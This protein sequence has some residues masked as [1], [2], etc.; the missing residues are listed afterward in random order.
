VPATLQEGFDDEPATDPDGN[1]PLFGTAPRTSIYNRLRPNAVDSLGSLAYRSNYGFTNTTDNDTASRAFPQGHGD[2]YG[3]YLK[4]TKV[5]LEAFGAGVVDS[6]DDNFALNLIQ[7]QALP[8]DSIECA[9][10]DCTEIVDD[11]GVVHQVG[12]HG[13]RSMATAMAARSRTAIRVVDLTFRRDYREHGRTVLV[14][15][16]TQRSWGVADWGHRGG[17]GAYLDWAVLNQLLVVPSDGGPA[18]IEAVDRT[19]VEQVGTLAVAVDEIQERVDAAGAGLDPLGLMPNVVPFR[20]IQPGQLLNFLEG[21]ASAGKSHYGIVRDAA[22]EAIRNARGIL[23]RANAAGNRLR[24]NEEVLS[25]FENQVVDADTA[26]TSR[27]IEIFGLPSPSDTSDNDGE[28]NNGD[29]VQEV[30]GVNDPNDDFRESGCG[31][32]CL[33]TPDLR[34]FLLDDEALETELGWENRLATG[35]IQ[36]TMASL[37]AASIKVNIAEL[38]LAQLESLIIDKAKSLALTRGEAVETIEI[39]AEACDDQLTVIGRM[40]K[41]AADRRLREQGGGFL[42]LFVG[43]VAC[44]GGGAGCGELVNG[45]ASAALD[46]VTDAF[47]GISEESLSDE[48]FDIQREELRINCWQTAQLTRISN[49]QQVRALEIEL[50]NLMRSTPQAILNLVLARN[51]ARQ[52]LGVLNK[53]VQAGKRL[54]ADRTRIRRVST[55]KLQ[56]FRW[57]D[58]AFR[59]FR[60]HSLEQYG[61]FYDLAARYVMLAARAFA[62]EYNERAEVDLQIRNLYRERLLGSALATDRGL[63]SII[64]RLDTKRQTDD[65]NAR[66][67]KLSLFDNGGDVFSIR[68]NLLGMAINPATDNF[69]QQ[70][71]KNR[72]YKKTVHFARIWSLTS[73]KTCLIFPRSVSSAVS[74]ARAMRVRRLC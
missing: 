73:S 19:T 38:D 17:T 16:D 45:I 31:G 1:Y 43:T 6:S 34:N 26:L 22:L 33:G 65:F 67:Q 46:A 53:N 70:K 48:G 21:G 8:A 60:N 40:E 25:E 41:M 27:L 9:T 66:L 14:D 57:R 56:Q 47:T 63:E 68:K 55:D 36:L 32:E 10:N 42:K 29:G 7:A 30:L 23:Q 61:A 15:T 13:I 2:A 5:Y 35:E 72:A 18:G 24:G 54:I 64:A 51:E 11:D 3:Y 74:T 71:Q 49:D 39:K 59:T 28:D 69:E 20:I 12:S 37:R 52:A 44:V 4:A 58:M 50:E 62:Y